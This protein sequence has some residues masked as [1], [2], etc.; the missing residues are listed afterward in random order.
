MDGPS[1]GED[2]RSHP[3]SIFLIT[4]EDPRSRAADQSDL[5]QDYL[6]MHMSCSQILSFPRVTPKLLLE[7]QRQD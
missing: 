5:D 4:E 3:G 1:S 6:M 2:T 7:P